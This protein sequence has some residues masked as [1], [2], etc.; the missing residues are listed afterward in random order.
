[1][2]PF[3]LQHVIASKRAARSRLA[4]LPIA[5]KLR[6]LDDLAD[7]EAVIRASRKSK[8]SPPADRAKR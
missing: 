3:N 1:M 7:R 2:T 8:A 4:A 5:E 6:I